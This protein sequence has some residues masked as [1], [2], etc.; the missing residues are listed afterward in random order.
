M[1]LNGLTM[2]QLMWISAKFHGV[3]NYSD[4]GEKVYGQTGRMVVNA[5]IV[6]KQ[7][8]ACISYLYFVSSQIDFVMC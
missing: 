2:M 6:I 7:L 3:T 4:L 8:G 1:G 5:C